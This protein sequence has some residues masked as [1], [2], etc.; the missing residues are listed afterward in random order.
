MVGGAPRGRGSRPRDVG[1]CG[2]LRIARDLGHADLHGADPRHGGAAV[3]PAEPV[4]R[5]RRRHPTRDA[6]HA[7]PSLPLARFRASTPAPPSPSGDSSPSSG[8]WSSRLTLGAS[9]STSAGSRGSTAA[10]VSIPV[11]LGIFGPPHVIWASDLSLHGGAVRGLLPAD[12]AMARLLL[13]LLA[14]ERRSHAHL[15]GHARWRR[16]RCSS[17]RS[18]AS[19]CAV[20]ATARSLPLWRA[21]RDR[22]AIRSADRPRERI[23]SR[24]V[25]GPPTRSI[26]PSQRRVCAASSSSASAS[27]PR[28]CT[29][30]RAVRLR[31]GAPPRPRPGSCVASK[32]PRRRFRLALVGAVGTAVIACWELGARSRRRRRSRR[33]SRSTGSTIAG[34]GR[35]C[36]WRA[37]WA[38]RGSHVSRDAATS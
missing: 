18:R 15:P 34:A 23:R 38:C 10:W 24:D 22:A 16:S 36:S 2:R 3:R 32:R 12:V 30:G 26:A 25:S 11:L 6:V 8:S 9:F 20:L 29:R 1:T 27:P 33:G 5:R 13:T 19:C 35:S 31:R 21:Q 7:A 17:T 37:S 28:S 14:L 4:S